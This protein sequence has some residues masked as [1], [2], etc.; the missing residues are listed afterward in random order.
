MI[1]DSELTRLL[2]ALTLLLFSSLGVGYIF[3]ALALP[4]VIGEIFA[5]ILLGPSFFGYFLPSLQTWIFNGFSEQTKVL[6][7]FYWMGLILLMF[8][9]GFK[10]STNFDKRKRFLLL[11]L[12]AG[13][14]TLPGMLGFFTSF[15]VPNSV[16]P[17]QLSFSLIIAIAAAVTSIPVLTSI[18]F[19]LEILDSS[20]A[21]VVLTAAAIQDL[22][23]WVLLSFAL[24]IQMDQ[25][26]KFEEI[27]LI[28][29]IIL[30]T[31]IYSAILFLIVPS[32][33]RF[34]GPILIFR[35]PAGSLIG[36]T[37]L[38]C[39]ALVSLAS[40]FHINVIFGA[41]LAGL[42]IGRFSNSSLDLVKQN[43]TSISTWFFVPIYFGLIGL[44]INLSANFNLALIFG[45]LLVSSVIKVSS[46]ALF[47]KFAG[48]SWGR[49]LD[50]GMT[51]NARGG[52]GIVLA[53]LAYAASIV[54]EELFVSLVMT[55]ILTSLISG[56]W[57]R[58]RR[59]SIIT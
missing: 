41:L 52:P 19:D 13:G 22:I 17:N 46:V 57:L 18:F 47:V 4:R 58:W 33:L 56:Q 29:E 15:L 8:T 43:I 3:S 50:F 51:M 27:T 2:L 1:L 40:I 34:L 45:F 37:M 55:S 38:F 59:S 30:G 31:L 44:Q 54:D 53:S 9:A 16:A 11:M 12:I 28:W 10:V 25:A 36:Y 20:F 24:A 42:V 6:S 49:S 21:Q 32:I 5:G 7:L 35:A 23:L 14:L 48:V 26:S 39:L